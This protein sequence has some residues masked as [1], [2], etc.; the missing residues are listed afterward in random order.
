MDLLVEL[1]EVSWIKDIFKGYYS[2]SGT[3]QTETGM[4]LLIIMVLIPVAIYWFI[5]Y[6][7]LDKRLNLQ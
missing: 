5:S 6:K 2:M 4:L 7:V 1:G 3:A